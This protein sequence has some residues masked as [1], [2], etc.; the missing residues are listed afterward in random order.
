M[1]A[2]EYFEAARDAARELQ[3]I[4]ERMER[5]RSAAELKA[6]TFEQVSGG[7]GDGAA[8]A[9]LEADDGR[10]EELKAIIDGAVHVLYGIKG[11]GGVAKRYGSHYADA[12]LGLYLMLTPV[13]ELA[14][15]LQVSAVM[16][17]RLAALAF[18]K[19]DTEGLDSFTDSQSF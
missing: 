11:R 3:A 7:G 6:Q 19:I 18:M 9:L 5:L 16:V 2:R 13:E 10:A 12:V 4:I 17:E 1:R 8:L 14:E 15:R